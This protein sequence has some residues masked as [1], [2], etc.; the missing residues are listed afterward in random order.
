MSDYNKDY[1]REGHEFPYICTE[2]FNPTPSVSDTITIPVYITDYFQQEYA[3][4]DDSERFTLRVEVDGEVTTKT[5]ISAGVYNLNLGKLTEGEHWFS[6]QVT[7]N[8]GLS[9]DRL[10]NELYVLGPNNTITAAKTYTVTSEDL[11]NY[12]ITLNL[13]DTAT[14]EQMQNNRIGLTN[15]F[16]G[17]KNQGFKKCVLP[18]GI[19]RVNKAIREATNNDTPISIPSGFTVDLNG[20]TVKMHVYNDSDYTDGRNSMIRFQ[21]CIDSHLVNGTLEGNYAE[22]QSAGYASGYNGEGDG[23]IYINGGKYNTTE[24]L[25]IKQISGYNYTVNFGNY[26]CMEDKSTA[27]WNDNTF[28]NA[29]GKTVAK[30]GYTTSESFDLASYKP[31]GWICASIWLRTGGLKGKHWQMY[32]HFYNGDTFLETIAG[33]QFRR[34]RIPDDATTVKVSFICHASEVGTIFLHTS[35]NARYCAAKNIQMIDN[36]TCMNPNQFQHLLLENI[37]FTRSGQ[38]I[39][40]AEIDLEDGWEQ[41][42]DLYIR[43]CNVLESAGSGDV[44]AQTGQNFVFENNEG[45]SISKGAQVYGCCIRNNNSLS[46]QVDLGNHTKNTTRVYNNTNVRDITSGGL[47]DS[48]N[49]VDLDYL[50]CVIKDCNITQGNY[51]TGQQGFRDAFENIIIEGGTLDIINVYRN[52]NVRNCTV[53]IRGGCVQ[54]N[55]QR[56]VDCTFECAE[57]AT[58][59]DLNIWE[60]N[61]KRLYKNCI[62]NAPTNIKENQYWN[63]GTWVNCTFNNDVTIILT[64]SRGNKYGDIAFNVCAFKSGLTINNS[65]DTKVQFNGCSLPETIN[66]SGTAKDNTQINADWSGGDGEGGSGATTDIFGKKGKVYT[67]VF[68]YK[69]TNKLTCVSNDPAEDQFSISIES[70]TGCTA[71]VSKNKVYVENLISSSGNIVINIQLG[72]GK[73]VK[74][75]YQVTKSTSTTVIKEVTAKQSELKQTVDGF[76]ATVSKVEKDI[77]GGT[78]FVNF[79]KNGDF[80]NLAENW[81]LDNGASVDTSI[82]YEGHNSVKVNVTNSNQYSWIGAKQYLTGLE[83]NKKYTVSCM[84]Y[85][86]DK[87]LFTDVGN[88]SLEVK[89]ISGQ[90]QV[91]L[92]SAT[93]NSSD[94]VEGQWTKL[95]TTFE[96]TSVYDSIMVFPYLYRD[97]TVWFTCVIVEEGTT[98]STWGGETGVIAQLSKVEQKADKINLLVQGET[99][100]ELTM[101]PNFTKLISNNITLTADHIN[102]NGYVSND[103]ANWSIDNEGNMRAENLKIEGDVGADTLSVNYIDNPCYPATLAGSVDLYINSSSGNDDYTLDDILQSYDEAEENSNDSLKKKFKTIQGAVDAIPRFLNNKTVYIT[104][105]TDST[106]D[107]FMRGIVGGAIRIYM[108]GKA[109]YGTLRSYVCGASINVYGGTRASNEGATGV[110]HPSAGL[111]F[112]GRA[113]SVGFE[114]SQYAAIYKVKVFAP[115]TLPSDITNTDKVCVAS[116][117]GTGSVYCKNVEIVNAVIGFRTNNVG[118]MHVNSS[119]GVAS[120]YGFQAT[121]GGIITIANNAQAGGKTGSTNKSAGGQVLYDSNGP[122]FATGNQST[123]GGSAPVISTTKTMTIKSTYGDTYRSTV[124]NNWKKDGTAR[125]GDYGYGDCTGCWFFGTAFSELKGC[126][127]SKV[128]ITITRQGGGSSSAVG[129]VVRTHNYSARPSGAPTLSSSSYGTLSLATGSTGTLTIT[130]STV[131]NGIKNGTIKGFGIRST[132]DSSHYAV[133]S[134]NVTVKITYKE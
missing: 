52:L 125:Q 127:I 27:K 42:Q 51:T 109:L 63:N 106:E 39:T 54:S 121:T 22:R 116:Q 32:Y 97:G 12:H 23:C 78:S 10:Y 4:N 131:L 111:S 20:S 17:V 34:C 130:N 41:G 5:N 83:M 123:D 89:G 85:V 48:A 117:S 47:Y 113:V 61:A 90:A 25:T 13:T 128:Q 84:Y 59:I 62:F 30:T 91:A 55:N 74:K 112:G 6:L 3:Y 2:Y 40:P 82:K 28:V 38:S 9:S 77:Y 50:K 66:Y 56:F 133:C 115:D 67:E 46:I 102:L 107:V 94:L 76:T 120:K 60:L 70:A 68:V 49:I 53:T 88:I 26:M 8:Y 69:G 21:D 93:V 108:N 64:T 57:E 119:S 24:N 124:Y 19:Y 101:T 15:L 45:L 87:S 37:D 29:E 118:A 122:K 1:E 80:S 99:A 96:I 73:V 98:A 95:V 72:D 65:G 86:R 105:E 31:Y 110:I 132:Y 126:T 75:Y 100:S 7:D 81:T 35:P 103:N 44:I 14:S 18:Q 79:I 11:T 36:R 92:S 71:G 43:N 58:T 114:A 104:M 134:G 16:V 129:L 33:C